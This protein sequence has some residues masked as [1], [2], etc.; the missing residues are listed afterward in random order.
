M[1]GIRQ[2][3]VLTGLFPASVTDSRETVRGI[4]A[5]ARLGYDTVELFYDGPGNA[6]V[7]RA[8]RGSSLAVIYHPAYA[9]KQSKLDLG[10]PDPA[11]RRAAVD[12][13]RAWIDVA[14]ELGAQALMVLSGPERTDARE[15]EQAVAALQESLEALCEAA[16]PMR[17]HLESF[18]N[19]GE[20]YLLMGPTARCLRM[21]RAV[22]GRQPNFSLTFDLSHA[23]QM[24]EDP[25]ASLLSIGQY[26]SHVHLANCVIRDRADPL[27]GDKHPPF[28]HAGGE[29][30]EPWLARFVRGLAE[31]GFFD[32]RE[33]TVGAEVITRQPA[34]PEAIASAAKKMLEAVVAALGRP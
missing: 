25:L 13:T 1:L 20:P 17:L 31:G 34:E 32:G 22:S 6:D 3:A 27:F 2:S 23:L 21:A 11:R 19:H 29:V 12:R 15:R 9:L 26:C 10:D 5:S 24:G 4:E 28:G 8:C 18:N 33:V 14:R 30:D 7:A 16:A